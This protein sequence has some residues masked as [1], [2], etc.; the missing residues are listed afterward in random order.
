MKK[1]TKELML[2][3]QLMNLAILFGKTNKWMNVKKIAD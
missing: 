2:K 1:N 3:E